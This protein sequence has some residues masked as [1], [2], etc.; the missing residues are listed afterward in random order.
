MG[1]GHLLGSGLS[2]DW[3]SITNAGLTAE[4]RSACV[5]RIQPSVSR[6]IVEPLTKMRGMSKSSS[7]FLPSSQLNPSDPP[8]YRAKKSVRGLLVLSGSMNSLVAERRLSECQQWSCCHITEF[9][10][11]NAPL[12]IYMHDCWPS[13]LRLFTFAGGRVHPWRSWGEGKRLGAC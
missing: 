2:F 5:P 7:H 4:K 12:R 8:Q 9:N 13:L 6:L 1:G 10:E 11:L 3:T